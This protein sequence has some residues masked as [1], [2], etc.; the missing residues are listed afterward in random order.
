VVADE[1]QDVTFSHNVDESR[2]EVAV[3]GELAGFSH[4]ARR[5]DVIVFTHT[6]V[7]P[8]LEGRG[9]GSRLAAYAL[10]DVR[11]SGLRVEARCPFIGAYIKRHA[12]YADLLADRAG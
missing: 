6:E 10:D 7:D 3:N 12:E 8:T 9:I 11:T 4:Y 2:Y 5:G 1:Q